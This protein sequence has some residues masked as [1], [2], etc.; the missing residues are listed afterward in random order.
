MCSNSYIVKTRKKL[1][2]HAVS[3]AHKEGYVCPDSMNYI[4]KNRD[5]T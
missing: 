5:L 1:K 4:Q 2:L 3:R